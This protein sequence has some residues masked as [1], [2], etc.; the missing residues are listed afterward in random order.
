MSSEKKNECPFNAFARKLLRHV[1]PYP[2]MIV[3]EAILRRERVGC[4][5]KCMSIEEVCARTNLSARDVMKYLMDL[6]NNHFVCS[7]TMCV[8]RASQRRR[9]QVWGV[10]YAHFLNCTLKRL[11]SIRD[12]IKAA[13]SDSL[14]CAQ[15]NVNRSVAEC[16][17]VNFEEACPVDPT[18]TLSE[19]QEYRQE[20]TL[21]HDLLADIEALK[22]KRPLASY[23]ISHDSRTLVT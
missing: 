19:K 11:H 16:I 15:C 4:R 18:H 1:F 3:F 5:K 6:Q 7:Y 20:L 22:S 17:D 12:T 9:L 14:Y 13:D 10:D 21:V 8:E 2:H 23:C